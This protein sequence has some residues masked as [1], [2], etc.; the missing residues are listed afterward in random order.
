[1]TTAA[2]TKK[3]AKCGQAN[4]ADAKFCSNCGTAFTVTPAAPPAPVHVAEVGKKPVAAGGHG[5]GEATTHH[6]DMFYAKIFGVLGIIT[7]V[8]V[9]LGSAHSPAIKYTSLIIL[10]AL[11]FA[12]V[13][14]FFMHLK[15]DKRLYTMLFVGPL[16]LGA[17]MLLALAALFHKFNP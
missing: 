1:M 11:K 4:A 12:L 13:V 8:E 10:S 7:I 3:C 16:F 6:T 9:F 2:A 14:M 15:G 17:T 5:E